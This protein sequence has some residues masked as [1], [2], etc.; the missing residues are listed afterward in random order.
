MGV[1]TGETH[2]RGPVF[3]QAQL[4]TFSRALGVFGEEVGESPEKW[5]LA[6]PG[7]AFSRAF[8][9]GYALLSWSRAA[10]KKCRALGKWGQNNVAVGM[11]LGKAA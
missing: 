4:F 7:V 8:E 3:R 10:W 5:R 11:A 9:P 2:G 1:Q 6:G